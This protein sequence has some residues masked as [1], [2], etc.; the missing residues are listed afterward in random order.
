MV[1]CHLAGGLGNYMFQIGAAVSLASRNNDTTLFDFSKAKKVHGSINS[2]KE[3]IFR[4]I[5]VG[6]PYVSEIYNEPSFAFRQLPYKDGVLLNGYFQS[7]KYLDREV[8]EPLFRPPSIVTQYIEDKYPILKNYLTTSVH[9]RRGDYVRLQD[10][11]PPQSIEY[12][13]KAE[14]LLNIT[15]KFIIFSDDIEWCKSN[16]M[17]DKFF[18]VEN[19]P[20]YMDLW[21]MSM[22]TN[23]IIANSSF[24]WWGAWLNLNKEKIV[25]APNLWFGPSKKL[26]TKDIVPKEWIR[27]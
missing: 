24:S 26:E 18:F 23:N 9:V 10:K 22:C 4:N 1:S 7:E 11:H 8:V 2:Y 13:R 5:E 6:I 25:V 3:N 27:I 14:E 16:F 21:I 15:E 20:D 17:G 19:E 12:Y